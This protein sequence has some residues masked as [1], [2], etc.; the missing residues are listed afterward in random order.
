MLNAFFIRPKVITGS[1]LVLFI[2][3]LD[4]SG[5]QGGDDERTIRRL[6]ENFNHAIAARHVSALPKFWRED[7]HV[8][9][10]AGR[11]LSGRDAVRAA[12]EA[13]FADATFITYIRTPGR[14]ELSASGVRAA[15]SGHWLGQWKKPDGM[16]EWRGT[17]HAMWRKESGEWLIQSE[18]YVSLRC[19]GSKECA[20]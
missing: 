7:V 14:V 19:S 20:E 6:R 10:G 9:T 2:V 12:F 5:K 18:L 16:M 3:L 11:Q 13:I 1:A 17:Y 4:F 8:T 15:E